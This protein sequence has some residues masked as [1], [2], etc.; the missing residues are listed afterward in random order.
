MWGRGDRVRLLRSVGP[1][2]GV[3]PSDAVGTVRRRRAGA[4]AQDDHRVDV[5]WDARYAGLRQGRL[6]GHLVPESVPSRMNRG[7]R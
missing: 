2:R 5:E 4:T 7:G 1:R 6:S 3:V